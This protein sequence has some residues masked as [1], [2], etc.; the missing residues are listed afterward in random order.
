MTDTIKVLAGVVLAASS[1]TLNDVYTAGAGVTAM[2]SGFRLVNASTDT[3]TVEGYHMVSGS[4]DIRIT[5]KS[6][7]LAA[8]SMY[9][10]ADPMTV[11]TGDKLKFSA[12]AASAIHCNIFGIEHTA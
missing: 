5:P 1:S 4:S 10:D 3:V 11:G 6:L 12:S 2:V 7:S 9:S 8:G